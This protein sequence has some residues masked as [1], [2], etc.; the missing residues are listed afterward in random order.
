MVRY[1]S[2]CPLVKQQ[3]FANFSCCS[4]R[5]AGC[6]LDLHSCFTSGPTMPVALFESDVVSVQLT[7][8]QA[9]LVAAASS[10]NLQA[11]N[12]MS[13]GNLAGLT[14]D[15]GISQSQV[16][17]NPYVLLLHSSTL[18]TR[19]WANVFPCGAS[20]AVP[21]LPVLFA[22]LALSRLFAY[23]KSYLGAVYLLKLYLSTSSN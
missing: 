2:C 23:S 3:L 16:N 20:L 19:G 1:D 6:L 8:S 18:H 10:G 17:H 5:K 13:T 21:L 15:P 4:G 12:S 7:G 11:L 9:D 14:A 22:G